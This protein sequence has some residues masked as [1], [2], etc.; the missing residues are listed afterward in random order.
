VAAKVPVEAEAKGAAGAVAAERLQEREAV[1]AS[2]EV[3]E[4]EGIRILTLPH[5]RER[6]RTSRVY[7][8]NQR[9]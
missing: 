7:G 1:P 6:M 5:L 3:V 8:R 2:A 4:V 9:S